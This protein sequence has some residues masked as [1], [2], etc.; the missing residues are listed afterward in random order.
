MGHMAMK[1][2]S[3]NFSVS[4]ILVRCL[5]AAAVFLK[6]RQM[7]NH[8]DAK[9]QKRLEASMCRSSPNYSRMPRHATH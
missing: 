5:E 4:L 6:V 8:A 2:F 3:A 7:A 9:G 1:T